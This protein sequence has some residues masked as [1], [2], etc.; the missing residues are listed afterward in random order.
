[1]QYKI[2]LC[3]FKPTL[4]NRNDNIDKMIKLVDKVEADL[5]IFPELATSGYVFNSRDE[6]LTVAEDFERG[7]TTLTFKELSKK[8]NCSYVIGFPE[9]SN[10]RLFNSSMLI[11][12]DGT[13]HLYRKIHL[14]NEEK[15]WF[16]D[17][18]LGFIVAKAKNNINIG[19]M[20]CFDWIFPESA[21]TLMLKG[22]QIIAHSSN[23]VLPWCQQAM[24][25]RSLENRVFSVTCNRIGKEING[26]QEFYFTGMSQIC[27]PFGE[28][29][30]KLGEYEEVTK[31]ITIDPNI[32][33]DKQVNQW[34]DII[35]DRKKQ[36]YL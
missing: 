24:I 29:L 7:E 16:E 21:R 1:M 32:S 14:F 17:G 18:N 9:I 19:L 36:Y 23:L 6:V 10:G 15:R 33:Y 3:Q 27:N 11:N 8:N 25:T 30:F 31:I 35:E 34:N 13:I 28:I 5:I 22:A 2:G 26:D 20:I 4:L 12:P